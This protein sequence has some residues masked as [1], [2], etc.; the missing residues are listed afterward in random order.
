ME[1]R[2]SQGASG[3]GSAGS[4][5]GSGTGTNVL[6]SRIHD[7][8]TTAINANSGAFVEFGT[9]SPYDAAALL[10]TIT[11]VRISANIGEPLAF[12]KGANAGA[13]A[14]AANSLFVSNQGEGPTAFGVA[15]VVGDRIWVR[16]LSVN[17]VASG[18]ITLN[19]AG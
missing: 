15:L 6:E 12:A 9:L 2:V 3:S 16:S 17:P 14:L 5:G 1:I 7:C 10:N 13:A 8:A 18:L 4:G 11:T 19:L